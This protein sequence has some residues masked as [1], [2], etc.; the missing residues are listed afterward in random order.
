MQNFKFLSHSKICWCLK[1]ILLSLKGQQICNTFHEGVWIF[2][3]KKERILKYVHVS[4]KQKK[5]EYLTSKHLFEC[6]KNPLQML[7]TEV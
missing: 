1:D 5:G 3:K 4:A 6:R 2:K 7:S